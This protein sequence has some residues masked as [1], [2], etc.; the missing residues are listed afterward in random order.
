MK[1]TLKKK[2]SFAFR[3]EIYLLGQDEDGINCWLEEPKWDCGWYWGF[4]YIIT[5][6]NNRNPYLAK[7]INSHSH[8]DG[9]VGTQEEYDHDKGCFVK[10]EYI[11]NIYNSPR[12]AKTVFSEKE[13]WKLSELF[14]QFYLLQDMA[15]FCHQGNTNTCI[16]E[17][18]NHSE[19][20][21][22]WWETINFEMIPKVTNEILK[23]LTPKEKGKNENQ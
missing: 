9:F 18:F 12:L 19:N 15:R 11:H 21:K 8:F 22:G 13:G 3:K 5:Y 14:K 20:I 23:I 4:G 2:T 1:N 16:V 17:G 7:D 10:G 6:T